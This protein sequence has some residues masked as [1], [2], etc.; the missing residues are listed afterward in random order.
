MASDPV[1]VSAADG[2]LQA[3]VDQLKALKAQGATSVDFLL[4]N[5]DVVDDQELLELVELELRELAG[6]NGLAVGSITRGSGS[7]GPYGPPS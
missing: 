6:T 1:V 2:P 7:S 5:T 4:T 3:T